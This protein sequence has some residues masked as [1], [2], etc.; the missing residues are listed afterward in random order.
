MKLNLISAIL[1]LSF[2]SSPSFSTEYIYRDLMAN[3]VPSAKCESLANAEKSANRPYKIKKITKKFCH[4]QGYGWGLEKITGTGTV[5]CNECSDSK[6]LQ[7]CYL[8]DVTVTCKRIKPGTVGM[9]P[10]KG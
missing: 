2:F 10:G 9:L 1:A 3:T 4:T 5:T 8:K 6:G 7:K